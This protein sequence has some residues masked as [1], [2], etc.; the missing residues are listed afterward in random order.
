VSL[1]PRACEA[2]LRRAHL[3]D[4]LAPFIEKVATGRRGS[5]SPELLCLD[6][7][8]LARAVGG[9]RALR[10]LQEARTASPRVLRARLT[11][12]GAWASCLHDE[13]YPGALRDSAEAPALLT[14]CGDP[15]LLGTLTGEPVVTIVGSRRASAYGKEVA[16][17]IG[18]LLARADVCVVS[19]MASG[20]DSESHRGA[21][22]GSGITAAVLGNGP[23][24]PYPK[25]K[26][27]LHRELVENG[28][29]L[30]EAL[31]GA[32]P[33]RWRFPARNRIMAA[34][35]R[36]TVVIEAAARSGSLITAEMAAD[37]GRHIGAVPGPVNSWLSAGTNKLLADGAIVVR[38]AEDILDA[39]LGPGRVVPSAGAKLDP[40]LRSVLRAVERGARTPDAIARAGAA[41]PAAAAG[42]LARLELLGYARSDAAGRYERTLLAEPGAPEADSAA[43]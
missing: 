10:K 35:G 8:T 4:L 23:E 30:S 34:L 2:C 13:A 32:E 12:A 11:T 18:L 20:I 3:V 1:R 7:E 27:R 33:W 31:P 43:A 22:E 9:K 21:L 24:T 5:T 36:M 40:E 41:P 29:V 19:G 39:V 6:D 17:E 38:G 16:R 15:G 25:Q 42:A 26:R 28:L 14:G 37:L